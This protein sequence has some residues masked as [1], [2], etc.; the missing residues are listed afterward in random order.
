MTE[1]IKKV[2]REDKIIIAD[3]VIATIAGIA[4]MEIDEVV[5]MSGN[6]SDGIAEML[7]KR[8]FSK[9]IKVVVEGKQIVLDLSIIVKYGCRIH[10]VAKN[11]QDKVRN[12]VED[13]TGMSVVE[14]NIH[15]LGVNIEKDMK[16]RQSGENG[17]DLA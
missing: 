7:G 3:E 9:G 12:V 14:V 6:L 4:A 5:S 10:V 16:N 15:I 1:D 8:N 13:M 11:I 2:A 17:G